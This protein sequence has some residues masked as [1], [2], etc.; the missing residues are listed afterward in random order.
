LLQ[1]GRAPASHSLGGRQ[2]DRARIEE[3]LNVRLFHRTTRSLGLTEDGPVYYERCVRAAEGAPRPARA[4]LESGR[5]EVAGRL[6]RVIASAVRPPLRRAGAGECSCT[7][8]QAG[9]GA[10][11]SMTGL[12]DLIEDGFDLAIRN[13]QHRGQRLAS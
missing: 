5:R 1:A 12:W 13:G 6:A 11:R 4:A 3:R 7:I 8:P 2:G 10:F 9:T